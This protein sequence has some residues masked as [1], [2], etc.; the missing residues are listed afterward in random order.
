[1]LVLVL[2]DQNVLVGLVLVLEGQVLVNI[3][4][5]STVLVT[6]TIIYYYIKITKR[7]I[8]NKAIIL[9]W[10]SSI[11]KCND[12]EQASGNQHNAFNRL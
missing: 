11:I 5:I 4:A 12:E 2:K 10:F 8:V 1:M 3:T 7:A 9:F 6:I